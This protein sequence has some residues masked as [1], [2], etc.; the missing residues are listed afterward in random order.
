M[1]SKTF[2]HKC[3]QANFKHFHN[4][5]TQQIKNSILR[6]PLLHLMIKAHAFDCYNNHAVINEIHTEAKKE[7]VSTK[8]GSILHKLKQIQELKLQL[9]ER[10]NLGN[11]IHV[12]IDNVITD[13]K[14]EIDLAFT[15]LPD[16]VYFENLSLQCD[17]DTFFETLSI[18]LKNETLSFQSAFYSQKNRQKK[19][20]CN[21]IKA[22]KE[23]YT[24]NSDEIFR[25]EN[26]LSTITDIE[27]KEELAS[28]KGFERLNEEK[29][30]PYFLKL[31]KTPAGSESLTEI[32]N[33]DGTE[34]DNNEDRENHV[35][36]F[37]RNLYKKPDGQIVL[38]QNNE[39]NCK[40]SEFLG[41][42]SELDSVK[43]SKLTEAEKEYLER[44]LTL[45][46]LDKAMGDAKLNSAPG[47][48]GISNRFIKEFWDY[49]RVPLL[50]YSLCCF[51]K[52]TLNKTFVA[53]K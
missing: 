37:Y 15:Q 9:I 27:L 21:E 39:N 13:R 10:G 20:L 34:F 25:L 33:D 36:N 4:R 16:Q 42:V 46:E 53:Q 32:K 50:K 29:I 47:I 41:E 6:D 28:E 7:F 26:R 31:A 45:I 3:V 44:P 14:G 1:L 43:N 48:D 49:L 12:D 24:V 18:C 8:I 11:Q 17:D 5:N 19:V 23:N 35:L 38:Q 40:I 51:D 30:T 22:L 2:D 52:G